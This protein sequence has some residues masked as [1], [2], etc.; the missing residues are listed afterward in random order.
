[1][2]DYKLAQIC[3]SSNLISDSDL[4]KA[5]AL[6]KAKKISLYRAILEEALIDDETLGRLAADFYNVPFVRLA[7]TSVQPSAIKLIPEV[8]AK[9]HHVV[10]FSQDKNGL[11]VATS[12][13]HNWE[14]IEFLR[15]KIGE[16]IQV[17]FAT[18][19]DIE[20]TI[21]L[22]QQDLKASFEQILAGG[23]T[24]FG[25]TGDESPVIKLVDALIIYAYRNRASDIHIEPTDA[26]TQ[27][28]LRI[29]GVLHDVVTIP[30]NLHDS[31]VSRIKVLSKLRT[32]EHLSAQ[33]GKM[34]FTVDNEDFDIRV[35]IVPVV[36][37]EK[38]VLRLL[39]ERARQFTLEN[40]GI[41]EVDL[42]K[43]KAAIAKPYG[44]V[45]ATGPTGCGKTTTIYALVK[46]L[47]TRDK[48]IATIEDPVEYDIEGVNQIQVNPKTNLTFAEGLR[49]ILRQDPDVI[50]VGEIRDQETAKIAINAAMTGHLV[51]STVHTNDA[52]TTL[53]RLLDLGVEPFLVASTVNVICAQRLVRLVCSNCAVSKEI[54]IE[55]LAGKFGKELVEK[56]FRSRKTIRVTEGQGCAVCHFSGFAGRIGI[57][58]VLTVSDAIRQL[59]T[60]KATASEIAAQAVRVGMTL[61]VEDGLRKVE[62]G[63]TTIEEVL[64]VI[65]S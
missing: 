10:A 31:V 33:D 36:E 48:N 5:Q 46:V 45:L 16:E 51:L 21:N 58:E 4:K 49:S 63:L 28:R 52:A 3:Q 19:Q 20:E 30:K 55:E 18:E 54:T 35:S 9:K 17:Y 53:P 7:K 29:D 14:I 65:R 40:L 37:G 56:H 23:V 34:R 22:Y 6:A 41:G 38:V 39:S 47:N 60:S 57:F 44:V 43:L 62:Q 64:R 25:K 61:M 42:E 59:I 24:K 12:E 2:D 32:D 15:K 13:P 11:K 50:F 27:I 8:V 1:M 26:D